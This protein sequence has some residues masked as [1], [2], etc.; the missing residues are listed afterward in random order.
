MIAVDASFLIRALELR[1]DPVLALKGSGFRTA[2]I[3]S[4]VLSEL[5]ALAGRRGKHGALARAFFILMEKHPGFF[6]IEKTQGKGDEALLEL[7]LPVATVDK[8]LAE[9]AKALGRR[10]VTIKNTRVE[11][12]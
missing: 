1:I 11:E 3:P 2:V 12:V 8:A 4:P 7:N 9:R 6:I 5:K 10:V